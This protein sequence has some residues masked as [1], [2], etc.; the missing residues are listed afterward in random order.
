LAVFTL[1]GSCIRQ[2]LDDADELFANREH[3]RRLVQRDDRAV[4][5]PPGADGAL[6]PCQRG[7]YGVREH[8]E[9]DIVRI[10][11]SGWL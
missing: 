10:L 7:L 8:P 6:G 1:A 11:V 3:G 9:E 5:E 2:Y 4:P